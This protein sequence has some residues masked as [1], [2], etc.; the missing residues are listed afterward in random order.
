MTEYYASNR[1]GR[2]HP[3]TMEQHRKEWTRQAREHEAKAGWAFER[4]EEAIQSLKKDDHLGWV[5]QITFHAKD[6]ENHRLE[7]DKYQR[8]LDGRPTMAEERDA[9]IRSFEARMD[10]EYQREVSGGWADDEFNARYDDN[11]ERYAAEL[12]DLDL[13]HGREEAE[14]LRLHEKEQ[15]RLAGMT[16][17]C[18]AHNEAMEQSLESYEDGPIDGYD[19]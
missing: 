16:G 7:A 14:A 15:A 1:R 10:A 12:A 2:R 6:L 17:G 3:K 18:A 11:R 4:L 19:Y 5:Q 9:S 13:E 8:L